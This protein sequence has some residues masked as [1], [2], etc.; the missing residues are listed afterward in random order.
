MSLDDVKLL[1]TLS[2]YDFTTIKLSAPC[3]IIVR[4]NQVICSVYYRSGKFCI[5]KMGK[6]DNIVAAGDVVNT[7]RQDYDYL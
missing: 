7:I 4:G 1:L 3:I 6:A 5:K 2:G